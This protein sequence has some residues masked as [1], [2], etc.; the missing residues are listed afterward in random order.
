[1]QA[2]IIFIHWQVRTCRGFTLAAQ[3]PPLP[4]LRC[5]TRD[6]TAAHDSDRR[7]NSTCFFC[8]F[9]LHEIGG[10]IA[11]NSSNNSAQRGAKYGAMRLSRG[12][13]G[14]YPLQ[15]ARLLQFRPMSGTSLLVATPSSVRR[16]F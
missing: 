15:G 12:S 11:S 6:F 8:V 14:C 3:S 16:L 13:P 7:S 2:I 9:G 10:N 5:E 1:M 4:V